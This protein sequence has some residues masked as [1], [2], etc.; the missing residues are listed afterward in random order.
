[1]GNEGAITLVSNPSS[2]QNVVYYVQQQPGNNNPLV[3]N[4]PPNGNVIYY[5]PPTY[6]QGV[7][8]GG[9]IQMPN[10]DNQLMINS[11]DEAKYGPRVWE[12]PVAIMSFLVALVFIVLH[13][14]NSSFPLL[15]MS[16]IFSSLIPL[17]W[18]R[19]VCYFGYHIPSLLANNLFDFFF[20]GHGILKEKH[21]YLRIHHNNI[22]SIL[23]FLSSSKTKKLLSL[24]II[25]ITKLLSLSFSF[26]LSLQSIRCGI[27]YFWG[28]LLLPPV[29]G[30]K[31]EIYT[32]LNIWMFD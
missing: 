25:V 32:V 4:P 3:M 26:S 28:C 7:V 8:P 20:V 22:L 14:Q 12:F 24:I 29:L 16:T 11:A 5:V 23:I 9:G 15:F 27:C 31:K 21:I 18:I 13:P 17:D 10:N 19:S 1:M 2:Q 6:P 30:G